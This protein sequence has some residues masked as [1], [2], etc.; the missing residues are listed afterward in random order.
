M[1]TSRLAPQATITL[2]GSGTEP[3]IKWYAESKG[4][5]AGA[6]REQ[7]GAELQAM[8]QLVLDEMLQP[9]ANGLEMRK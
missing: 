8:V 5:V 1:N 7:I 6:S 3:K 4:S 9:Q 2:R